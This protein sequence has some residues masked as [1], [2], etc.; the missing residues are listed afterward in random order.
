MSKKEKEMTF[1]ELASYYDELSKEDNSLELLKLG[2]EAIKEDNYQKAIEYLTSSSLQGNSDAQ[3]YLGLLFLKNNDKNQPS[4]EIGIRYLQL[5]A[6]QKN[7]KTLYLLGILYIEG[8]KENIIRRTR[9]GFLCFQEEE[10]IAPSDPKSPLPD[11]DLGIKYLKQAIELKY[12]R[13]MKYLFDYYFRE[14]HVDN[15]TEKAEQLAKEALN[16]GYK[17]LI[18]SLLRERYKYEPKKQMEIVKYLAEHDDS[19]YQY[20]YGNHL[21][22]ET[23]D[24]HD[25]FH[26]LKRAADNGNVLA[27][28]KYG[29][30]NLIGYADGHGSRDEGFKYLEKSARN[31]CLAAS[32]YL[33][34]YYL[35]SDYGLPKDIKRAI[36]FFHRAAIY[37]DPDAQIALGKVFLYNEKRLIVPDLAI[38]YFGL[39]AEGSIL[40]YDDCSQAY[41][42]DYSSDD[43]NNN[44]NNDEEEEEEEEEEEDGNEDKNDNDFNVYALRKF[45]KDIPE[46]STSF[47]KPY[48]KHDLTTIRKRKKKKKNEELD[49]HV[50]DFDD[51]LVRDVY[52]IIEEDPTS[53]K[54]VKRKK[55]IYVFIGAYAVDFSRADKKMIKKNY[56][57]QGL[58]GLAQA[59]KEKKDYTRSLEN[60]EKAISYGYS[61]AMNELGNIYKDGAFGEKKPLEALRLFEKS[62]NEYRNPDALYYMGRMYMDGCGEIKKDIPKGKELIKQAVHHGSSVAHRSFQHGSLMSIRGLLI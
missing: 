6:E 11:K 61:E 4:Y 17:D 16:L 41:W 49:D 5:S 28:Y 35:H 12:K 20:I 37:R 7:R 60:Y 46:S 34:L 33:G 26:Y 58:L 56:M 48:H 42:P 43:D 14:G 39:A 57:C 27:M 8:F 21:Y 44:E 53:K 18:Y 9:R 45:Y 62:Y 31:G 59:Y 22:H 52:K 24:S 13:A 38:K 10:A 55:K 25:A 40:S 54:K 19:Y 51:P 50:E 32:Y 1:N 2:K 36:K 3:R 29:Y 15:N 30:Y 47:E 23:N